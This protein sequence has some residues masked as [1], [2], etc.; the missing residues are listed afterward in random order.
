MG[1]RTI[2]LIIAIILGG[3]A[4]WGIFAFLTNVE[5]DARQGLSEV[6]VF[7]AT[8][9]IDRGAEGDLVIGN[10]VESTEI[11]ELL[12]DNSITTE[13]QLR[14]VLTGR[15]A[16]GPIS[17]GQIVT[18]D[19]W[20]DAE[21]EVG[22]LSELIAP[23]KQAIVVRPDEVKAVGGFVRP[24]DN[25]NIIVSAEL[26]R[27]ATIDLLKNPIGRELLGVT[28]L[29]DDFTDL[30]PPE[31][32]PEVIE[33]T[34]DEFADAIPETVRIAFHALQDVEVLAIGSAA[35][36]GPS[37]EDVAGEDET[38]IAGVEAVGTQ[39]LTLEVG[40]AD[41]EKVVFIFDFLNPWL[42][43]T[44]SAAPFEAFD[45]SGTTID[46]LLGDILERRTLEILGVVEDQS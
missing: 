11:E 1:R 28:D 36:G 2:V 21:E 17:N 16:R 33:Q 23:G 38:V 41:A 13:A 44:S 5:D 30:L 8:Q 43:L 24:G 10:F 42:T 15:V 14:D 7:R 6:A 22:S 40:S 3:L 19:L 4:A 37:A 34:L 12:P 9:F 39:L 20:A 46:E 27:Q 25:V 29:F 26:S 35:R 45:T 32:A 18:T 31:T